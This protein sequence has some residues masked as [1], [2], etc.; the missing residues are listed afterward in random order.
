MIKH[1]SDAREL[2]QMHGLLELHAHNPMPIKPQKE[3][4]PRKKL[5]VHNV[6]NSY[7][8]QKYDI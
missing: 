7:E 6:N 8:K 5:N 4:K 1:T 3:I 2:V